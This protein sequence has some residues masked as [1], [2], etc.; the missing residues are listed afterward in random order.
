MARQFTFAHLTDVHLAPLPR[1]AP[2]HWNLKRAL[3]YANWQRK[4]RR[5]HLRSVVDQLLADLHRQD[6]DH[7]LVSGDLINIG[8]PQEHEQALDWLTTVGRPQDVSVVPGN[9]D[10]YCPLW[11]DI[12]VE[13]WRAYMS[14]IAAD[15]SETASRGRF[16]FV[17]HFA[18]AAVVGVNSSVTTPP[19]IASG[20]A[21]E[22]Q[23]VRL[24]EILDR[25]GEQ[26][27][28][29]IVMIHHPPLPGQA[30]PGRNLRDA[31][32][33]A[34]IIARHGAELIVHGHNHRNMLTYITARLEEVPVVGAPSFSAGRHH[35]GD[36]HVRRR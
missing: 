25:L 2:R 20:K 32:R 19:G 7:V 10:I 22:E 13:R 5:I 33:L 34:Q 3:G 8:M 9:H 16:P 29:R 31:E 6:V 30:K 15:G 24:A 26:G 11:T 21:G 17:R 1:F 18:Q 4:R 27:K 36:H 23:L 28:W 12:G 14:D 35:H